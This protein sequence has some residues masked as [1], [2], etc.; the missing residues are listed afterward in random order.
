MLIQI[1]NQTS[2]LTTICLSLTR[3]SSIPYFCSGLYPFKGTKT[4]RHERK[5][6]PHALIVFLISLVKSGSCILF[7]AVQIDRLSAIVYIRPESVAR[8][9]IYPDF[10]D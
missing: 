6:I 1:R 4:K 3:I 5:V 8:K 7:H 10:V 9:L 2:Y